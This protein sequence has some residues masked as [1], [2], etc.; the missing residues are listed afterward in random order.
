MNVPDIS[1]LGNNITSLSAFDG[2][3]RSFLTVSLAKNPE[4]NVLPV[5][6]IASKQLSL[7][8]TAITSL[9]QWMLTPDGLE[10]R[11]PVVYAAHS[12]LCDVD[13]PRNV[14]HVTGIVCDRDDPFGQGHFPLEL[15]AKWMLEREQEAMASRP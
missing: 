15:A 14:R 4:L 1:L 12:P 8:R 11:I 7:E 2:Y 10:S 9:P 3:S 13:N 5:Q 6:S